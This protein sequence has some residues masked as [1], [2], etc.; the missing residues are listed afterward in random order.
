MVK[1]KWRIRIFMHN[2]DCDNV[3]EILVI[4][5]S[6]FLTVFFLSIW[7]H[8]NSNIAIV[9]DITAELQDESLYLINVC[10]HLPVTTYD[11]EGR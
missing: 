8:I 1:G 4:R 11:T 7:E 6:S 9:T 10:Y 2:E 5:Q 3:F